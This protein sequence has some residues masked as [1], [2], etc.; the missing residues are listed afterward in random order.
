MVGAIV[1][2]LPSG[3]REG[4]GGLIITGMQYYTLTPSTCGPPIVLSAALGHRR[5]LLVVGVEPR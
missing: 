1:G 3:I 2:E 5:L 4:L